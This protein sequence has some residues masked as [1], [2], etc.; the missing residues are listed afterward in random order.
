MFKP[1]TSLSAE[2]VEHLASLIEKEKHAGYFD[3]DGFNMSHVYWNNG[4]PSCIAGYCA[5]LLD[6]TNFFSSDSKYGSVNFWQQQIIDFLGCTKDQAY[7]LFYGVFQSFGS[8][9][10]VL[11][12]ITPQ[13]AA[14]AIRKLIQ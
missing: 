3:G 1:V 11:G 5:M 8:N 6:R 7:N 2:R 10:M 4:K 9:S 13:Q 14:N 12:K